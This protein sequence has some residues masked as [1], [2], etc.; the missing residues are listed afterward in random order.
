M[1]ISSPRPIP[2][3]LELGAYAAPAAAGSGQSC[4]M[5]FPQRHRGGG[6]ASLGEGPFGVEL[7]RLIP[8]TTPGEEEI[9]ALADVGCRRSPLLLRG[10]VYG[11]A[12]IEDDT[13]SA[14]ARCARRLPSGECGA[15]TTRWRLATWPFDHAPTSQETSRPAASQRERAH[16]ID[17]GG[18]DHGGMLEERR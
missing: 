1:P 9:S 10:I 17:H 2:P 6:T 16:I 11:Q 18:I 5:R 4:G 13:D 12:A 7:R 14:V 8:V 3:H 15:A